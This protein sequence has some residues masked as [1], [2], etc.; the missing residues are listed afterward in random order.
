MRDQKILI[1]D[2]SEMNRAL[3]VDILEEQ[4]QT[5]EAQD[6]SEAI[7]ILS[8][9]AAEFSLILLDIF[10]PKCS[11]F[12]VL[13]YM[14]EYRL[15]EN[16]AVIMISSDDSNESIKK[17]YE[18]GAFDYISRPFDSM[19]VHH[20]VSNTMLLYAKQHRLAN[21]VVEQIY[22]QQKNSKLMVSILSHIVEF[23]NGES[24]QHIT[25]V[26]RITELLLKQLVQLTD[27]YSLTASEI[28]LIST[29]SAFHDIG[30]ISIP[31][32][33]INKPG[34]LTD[35]EFALMKQ[36]AAIGAD[37]LH[38][39]S[40]EEQK[41]ELVKKAYEICRWH[42]ERYDGRGYPDGL[43]GDEIPISA[44]VVALADVYDALTSERCYKPA[45]SHEEAVRMIMDGQCGIFNP[46]LLE[47]LAVI[48]TGIKKSKG[49]INTYENESQAL[50]S[51]QEK[52]N[53]TELF[54]VKNSMKF[55]D[56]LSFEQQ[57]FNFLSEISTDILF[58]YNSETSV[59]LLN[60]YGAKQL[61]LETGVLS[62][63]TSPKIRE[64]VDPEVFLSVQEKIR[65]A[66]P[67]KPS[68]QFDIS[69][70]IGVE[71][72]S[73]HGIGKTIWSSEI[74]GEQLGIVGVLIE[75]GREYRQFSGRC[76]HDMLKDG[77]SE[78]S[79]PYLSVDR[80][81]A[82]RM[83]GNLQRIF[84][85]VYLVD[86]SCERWGMVDETGR[87][88]PKEEYCYTVWE[89]NNQCENCIS[90]RVLS[91]KSR[92]SKLEFMGRD[93]FYILASY[94]E[95]DGQ[96]YSL[97]MVAKLAKEP[98]LEEGGKEML[99]QSI[100]TY[101]DRLFLDSQ[102][103]VYNRRYY[104]EYLK[105][106]N[107]EQAVVVI[108]VDNLKYINDH[109]GHQAGDMALLDVTEILSRF[110]SEKDYIVRYGGDEFVLVFHDVQNLK[111]I[112]EKIRTEIN[113]QTSD[114]QP[115]IRL[116]VSI[117]GIIGTGT[118]DSLFSVAD[119]VMYQAK[120]TKNKAIVYRLDEWKDQSGAGEEK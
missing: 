28:S 55:M 63:A 29:A 39:L 114:V 90:A 7:D 38:D 74:N 76:L 111:E 70:C 101:N 75:T 106:V 96:P 23:R 16:T 119:T 94:L 118:V 66:Q 57:R 81:E 17:S 31:D 120:R 62:P 97:T 37:M 50:R 100:S 85:T 92:A 12:E 42:H 109:C 30:K 80:K 48:G 24:G 103:K 22:E 102:T 58:S 79:G 26:E 46:V 88:I 110:I 15:L 64:I 44:Q 105:A 115:G 13:A 52:L 51:V 3:L 108:D 25:H 112:L 53:S 116:S 54:S 95:I 5:E 21:M 69:F 71:K 59:L 41:E 8:R 83:I 40:S 45:Y 68:V 93:V 34:R 2:D 4:Y 86:S 72:V 78:P 6:G 47:C 32:E 82:R 9:R 43:K 99:I 107:R 84:D 77:E 117:G 98:I 14:N 89:K 65:E 67:D 10:M 104:E 91:S 11:G 73:Y 49:K 61:G 1:V 33:I 20:R 27:R 36:H 18:M 87:F 60:P 56:A 35:E 113:R 19:L